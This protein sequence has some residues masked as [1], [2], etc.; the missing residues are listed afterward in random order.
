MRVISPQISLLLA[1]L[2]HV[3][4]HNSPACRRIEDPEAKA[5]AQREATENVKPKLA[6]LNEM[7]VGPQPLCRHHCVTLSA[8]VKIVLWRISAQP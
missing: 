2:Q 4:A 1:P 3:D 7:V 8:V 5:N 6:K